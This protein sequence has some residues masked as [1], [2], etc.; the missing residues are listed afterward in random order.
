LAVSRLWLYF[1]P[2]FLP[3]LNFRLDSG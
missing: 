1:R 3:K 2:H